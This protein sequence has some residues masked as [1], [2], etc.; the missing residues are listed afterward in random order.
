MGRGTRVTRGDRHTKLSSH[1]SVDCSRHCYTDPHQVGNFA[2]NVKR[3][4]CDPQHHAMVIGMLCEIMISKLTVHGSESTLDRDVVS[5]SVE[6]GLNDRLF[7]WRPASHRSTANQLVIA[8]QRGIWGGEPLRVKDCWS[9]FE[10]VRM[11]VGCSCKA[12]ALRPSGMHE[13]H[14]CRP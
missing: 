6:V 11:C 13:H 8:E 4:L 3:L 14:K 7:C 12:R 1:S 9:R 2:A 5:R 10:A